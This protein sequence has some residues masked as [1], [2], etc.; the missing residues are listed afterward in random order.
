MIRVLSN[1]HLIE[2]EKKMLRYIIVVVLLISTLLIGK[3][4]CAKSTNLPHLQSTLHFIRFFNT[5]LASLAFGSCIMAYN[6]LKQDS[7]FIISLMYLGLAVG[8]GLGH[9]DYFS[10]YDTE[11]YIS[12]YITLSTSLL[13]VSIIILTISPNNKFRN[14]IMNNKKESIVFVI[15]Y[16]IIFGF[17]ENL[18]NSNSLNETS[19]FFIG[20]NIF[21]VIIY[22]TSSINLF[23]KGIEKGEYVFVV[24]GSS[25]FMLALKAVYAIYG[26]NIVSFYVKLTSVSITYISSLIVIAGVF[27]ELYI[28][29]FKTKLL[30]ENLS[31][32]YNLVD[33]NKHSFMFICDE[34][35]NIKYANQKIKEDY[36]NSKDP[37]IK[38][39]ELNLKQ[40][41]RYIDES[42]NILNLLN[43]N[44]TWRGIIK[45][46]FGY[47]TI[48]CTVQ[49]INVLEDKSD[50]VVSYMDISD[51]ISTELELEKL[52]VYDKEK[53]QFI[54]NLS[55]E[56][57]TPLNIFYSTVQLLDKVS[58][59]DDKE[60]KQSY[61][62]YQKSLRINCKRMLRLINNVIDVLKID[63]QILKAKFENYDIVSIVENV[64]LEVVKYASL[65]SINIE[66]D[67][68]KEENII[69]CDPKLIERV[70]LNL[71]SN[72]IKFSAENKNIYV[73]LIS[74][75]DQIYIRVKDEGI[76]ISDNVKKL[77]FEKFV[78]VDKSLT[79]MNEGV[80][81]GLSISKS[82]IDLHHGQINV[83]SNLNMGSTFE[84]VLPNEILEKQDT[85]FYDIDKSS[86]ELELSDIYEI[87]S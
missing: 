27:C 21:L 13:R 37:D 29:I 68:N 57:R 67:T 1:K 25:L 40:K 8:I 49:R 6:R 61:Q 24:L 52:K 7:I 5:I 4:F 43:E 30:N 79:R 17:L 26:I 64:T 77:I 51:E 71:L 15:I 46:V 55:H 32:F 22:I 65:K 86:I 14:V 38:N 45:N 2:K 48:D 85:K 59:K 56:L 62:K 75:E 42:Y 23:I 60:F 78:Q 16:S 73:N 74:K 20:Y 10:F 34:N 9:I 76:G 54:Y 70:L 58:L 12:S 33:S 19:T 63:A 87:V 36:F 81:V 39:I 72:A 28:Y 66:F 35:L 50:I 82:I 31:I 3:I 53:R 69:K 47:K 80:G 44:G 11:F 41:L 83:F 18:L 84:I